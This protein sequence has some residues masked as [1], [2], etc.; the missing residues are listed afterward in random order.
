VVVAC[1]G[2]GTVGKIASAV[3]GTRAMLG[4]IPMGS[5][6]DFIKSVGIPSNIYEALSVLKAG[7]FRWIDLGKCNDICFINTLGFG[8]DGL[9]NRFFKNNIKLRG[10][11]G[12]AAA[13]ALACCSAEPFHAKITSDCVI[14]DRQVIMVTVANG[15]VE[16]GSFIVAPS[17]DI[18]D[19][20]LD[21]LI[22][23]PVPRLLIPIFLPCFAIGNHKFVPKTDFS[24][25]SKFILK[26]DKPVPI[27]A[28]GEVIITNNT[29]FEIAV[30]PSALKVIG[31]YK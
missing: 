12:Y 19:G 9:A 23:N 22:V 17:A 13:A 25:G 30:L 20:L 8:F 5:G 2:D 18:T 14:F 10:R 4:I 7:K 26:V 31:K 24:R 15:R 29:E 1:G 28:D 27:H 11:F 16:G 6:N 21:L 3:A